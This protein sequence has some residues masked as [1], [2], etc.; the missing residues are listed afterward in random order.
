MIKYADMIAD[1]MQSLSPEHQEAV[2][3]YARSLRQAEER[4][5]I[6]AAKHTPTP[7]SWAEM[8]N[9]LCGSISKEEA[10]ELKRITDEA[11]ETIDWEAWK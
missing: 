4:E 11:F 5:S 2:I 8:L 1:L 9:E 10:E 3:D 7:E 6:P